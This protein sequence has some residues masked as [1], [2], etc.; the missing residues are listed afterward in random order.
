MVTGLAAAQCRGDEEA[1]TTAAGVLTGGNGEPAESRWIQ[2]N[3]TIDAD[4]IFACLSAGDSLENHAISYDDYVEAWERA[5]LQQAEDRKLESV[6]QDSVLWSGGVRGTEIDLSRLGQGGNVDYAIRWTGVVMGPGVS[7]R[8]TVFHSGIDLR[9]ATF[10]GGVDFTDAEFGAGANFFRSDFI[11]AERV[12]FDRAIFNGIAGFYG[13]VNFRGP[14]SFTDVQFRNHAYFHSKTI[15]HADASFAGA[16]FGASP[17]SPDDSPEEAGEANF[18]AGTAFHGA[19]DFRGA[20]FAGKAHFHAGTAFH[21]EANFEGATFSLEHNFSDNT[22]KSN[23]SFKDAVFSVEAR[24][25]GVIFPGAASFQGAQFNVGATFAEAVFDQEANFEDAHFRQQLDFD[26]VKFAELHG[27]S[28]GRS[29]FDAAADFGG[30]TFPSSALFHAVQFNMGADFSEAK[31]E[32][33]VIF[34]GAHFHQKAAFSG[35][36]FSERREASFFGS[37][38]EVMVFF[39]EHRFPGP[40][41]FQDTQFKVGAYFHKVV[42]EKSANFTRARFYQTATFTEVEFAKVGRAS[43]RSSIFDDLALFMGSTFPGPASFRQAEFNGVAGFGNTVFSRNAQFERAKFRQG[44]G[45]PGVTFAE[46]AEVSFEGSIFE[47]VASFMGGHFSGPAS[48][49]HVQFK[50]QALFPETVFNRQAIFEGG[51]FSQLADF[52]GVEFAEGEEVSFAGSIFETAVAFG[53]ITFPGPASFQDARLNKGGSFQ[54]AV[55]EQEAN[56]EGATFGGDLSFR[57]AELKGK[58]RLVDATWEGRVDMRGS[59]IAEL[60]WDSDSRPTTVKGVFDARDATLKSLTIKDVYFSDLADFSDVTFG[61]AASGTEGKILFEDLIF[62]KAADFLRSDFQADA[63]F[64]NNRFRDLL[65]FTNSTFP[66]GTRLC[67][68]GNRIGE[69]LMDREHLSTTSWWQLFRKRP[70][71]RLVESRFRALE[72]TTSGKVAFPYACAEPNQRGNVH[73]EADEQGNDNAEANQ[74]N[75]GHHL[76]KIYRSIQSSFRNANDRWGENEAWY[77]GTVANRMA[78]NGFLN[79]AEAIFVDIPSRRGI[80]Y[81]R[82]LAVS[83][84]CVLFFWPVY[85]F[86]FRFVFPKKHQECPVINLA[87]PP[88]HRRAFRF[89]PFERM[90]HPHLTVQEGR[91]VSPWWD[92]LLLSCRAFFKLG[93]GSSYPPGSHAF[94]WKCVVCLEWFIG[95]V[96]LAHFLFVLKNVLPIALPFLGG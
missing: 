67:L 81:L 10:H 17:G 49:Q 96:L 14:A 88:E 26:G 61:E 21:G 18:H 48:F 76:Q 13:G 87:A 57:D 32:Q 72:L 8:N 80:D 94:V 11:G 84:L 27:V 9:D 12:R 24:F 28:F 78:G 51:R 3:A 89:R 77:L 41:S 53:R 82:A 4:G 7:G 71:E 50:M 43:F 19:A 63:I 75:S 58:L 93:L 22:F 6:I 36:Q 83:V 74:R 15:F 70:A 33:E 59:V 25:R 60:D 37:I 55:F 29:I 66:G 30:I 34:N 54:H 79:A 73:A 23:V 91:P 95:M 20:T 47:A 56:F 92:A 5:L 44:A 38:F 16:I 90:F 40:I 65:D 85:W 69:L 86:Y 2:D 52:D 46:G 45:F 68:S 64:V 31:F 35:V 1:R 39:E 62:E 42:F